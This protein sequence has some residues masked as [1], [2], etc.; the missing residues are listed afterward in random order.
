MEETTTISFFTG[1]QPSDFWLLTKAAGRTLAI[2]A[3]AI[4][5]GTV[6][7]C[8]FGWAMSA[9]GRKTAATIGSLLDVFRSIPLLILL[10]LFNSFFPIVGFPLDPF[11]SGAIVLSVVMA[12]Y[13][14]SIARAGI[15]AVPT[16]TKRA[17]RS[18]GLSYWQAMSHVT[19][20]IGT[21]AVFP[22]WIGISLSTLKDSSLVSAL[23]YAELL[24][25]SQKLI[26]RTQEPLLILLISGVFYFAL[27][28]P[29]SK[30]GAR[31]EQRWQST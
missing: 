2:S 21:R 24:Y 4:S 28:Y 3:I 25:Q 10:I 5:V 13:V 9:A 22:A 12:S 15:E 20:P 14:A 7:G 30:W 16:T 18:L 27:S 11:T 19:A 8:F 1:L 23:G 6:L 26:I 17:A 31:F 29:I